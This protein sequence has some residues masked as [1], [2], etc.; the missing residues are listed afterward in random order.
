MNMK[1]VIRVNGETIEESAIRQETAAMENLIAARMQGEDP[2][3]LQARAREWA[4]ENLIEAA[5]LRQAALREPEPSGP[6]AGCSREA[7]EQLRLES[8][9]DRIVSPAAMPRHKE[10]VA[11]YLKNRSSFE[12]PEKV[13]VGHIVK[14]VDER[15]SEDVALAAIERAR[16][17]LAAGKPFGQIADEMSD[18]AGNG[19]ELDWF[20]RGEMV[21]AFEDAVF[22]LDTNEVSGIIRTEF[23]FHLAKVLE[24]RPA[25]IRRLEEVTDQISKLLL[26]EKKQKRIH[27]YVDNL[28]ARAAI[29][30]E[31]VPG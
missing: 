31:E 26:E 13:R 14:N 1:T 11:W 28:R 21:Q 22:S 29:Q 15:T 5:L 3:V 2:V 19:G 17:D 30:R 23:G 27:Q 24:R 7:W 25:G 8:L 16:N 10:V 9:I 20:G 4:E 6:P 12:E 18:C